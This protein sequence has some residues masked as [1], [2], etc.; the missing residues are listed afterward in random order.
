LGLFTIRTDDE[1][2]VVA[3][4]GADHFIPAGCIKG[5]GDGL[6][7]THGGFQHELVLS[8]ADIAAKFAEQ[9]LDRGRLGL[10]YMTSWGGISL[11]GFDQPESMNIAREGC[12]VDSKAVTGE[13]FANLFLAGKGLLFEELHDAGLSSELGHAS[14]KKRLCIMMH[15]Y[16][17][18]VKWIL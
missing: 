6:G 14:P 3:G 11:G 4:N 8:L 1:N 5:D 18:K 15:N 9:A 16:A 13:A 17:V 10:G 2:G 12:L 7:A